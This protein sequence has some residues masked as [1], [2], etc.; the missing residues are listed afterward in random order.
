MANVRM[1]GIVVVI[2]SLVMLLG[3]SADLIE[4][5]VRDNLDRGSV[6]AV[7]DGVSYG[8]DVAYAEVQPN[9]LRI[10]AAQR[11]G[12]ETG[13]ILQIVLRRPDIPGTVQLSESGNRASWRPQNTEAVYESFD[14]CGSVTVTSFDGN[15]AIGTFSFRLRTF[16]GQEVNFINGTFNVGRI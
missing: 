2:M 8:D 14:G 13:N 4:Q 15:T 10:Y 5:F 7:I 9:T 1:A 16:E 3:C 6:T 11:T 12:A